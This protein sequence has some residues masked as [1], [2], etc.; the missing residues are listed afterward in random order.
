M[1]AQH[2]D[3][4]SG[5]GP[6]MGEQNHLCESGRVPMWRAVLAIGIVE[7]SVRRLRYTFTSHFGA[8]APS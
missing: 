3:S 2:V 5:F 6:L 8:R 7:P 4:P 1:S